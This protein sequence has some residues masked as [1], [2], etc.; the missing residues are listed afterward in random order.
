MVKS[1]AVGSTDV[2]KD[3]RLGLAAQSEAV[4]VNMKPRLAARFRE[5]PSF[6][7]FAEAFLQ[8]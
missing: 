2:T 3:A 7:L 1:A 4:L 8:F 6:L 5:Q